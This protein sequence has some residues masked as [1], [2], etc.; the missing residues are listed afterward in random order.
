M[1][2]APG[3]GLSQGCSLQIN[4]V[5]GASSPFSNRLTIRP[6][7]AVQ[8]A[9]AAGEEGL[10][11]RGFATL[12]SG[13]GDALSALRRSGRYD[14]KSGSGRSASATS[15]V[16]G[17]TETPYSATL[18]STA[19][20]NTIPTS[21]STN[22]PAWNGTSSADPTIGG[23][24]DGSNGDTTLTFAVTLAGRLGQD[25]AG[26][27]VRTGGG[28]VIDTILINP[29]QENDTFTLSNGLEVQFDSGR[30]RDNDF[31]TLDVFDSIGSAVNPDGRF[32][33][34]GED[35]PNFEEGVVV[36][37]GDFFVNGERIRVQDNKTIND[38]AALI[39]ASNAGVSAVFDTE[40]ERLVL[41][42]TE[43]GSTAPIDLTGDTS[44]FLAA[45][46]LVG[47]SMEI[48]VVRDLDVEFENAEQFGEVSSGDLTVNGVTFSVNTATD[49]LGDLIRQINA[50]EAGV[51]A[52]Y[53]DQSG[54][55]SI[56]AR[57]SQSLVLDDGATGFFAAL[58]IQEGV[59]RGERAESQVSFRSEAGLRRGLGELVKE[60]SAVFEGDV[61][62]YA[63]GAAKVIRDS[64]VAALEGTFDSLYDKEGADRLRSGLGLDVGEKEGE[65]RSLVIDSA[66]LTKAVRRNERDLSTLLFSQQSK[67]GRAGLVER[68]EGALDDAFAQLEGM[69]SPEDAIGLRLD[70]SG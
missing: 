64:L 18:R 38:V 22:E 24:Y 61:K 65:F 31:F 33:R 69:L 43:P 35:G 46:K 45:M 59:Y 15:G 2:S 25:P 63:S 50:S 44:G 57:G 52:F 5:N 40:S 34:T 51:T 4:G 19:E 27:E 3:A 20:I 13:L 37:N 14:D 58:D 7:G 39:T 55:F 26:L 41:T 70:V 9:V 32:D 49:S 47:A 42:N 28:Q 56:R 66:A 62:G 67:D 21:Y 30:W 11:L 8:A 29:G 12:V 16:L 1:A 36:T 23:I 53:D 17:L 6:L 10:S 60:L 54:R 48:D 68:L